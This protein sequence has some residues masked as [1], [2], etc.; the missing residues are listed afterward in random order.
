MKHLLRAIKRLR[1]RYSIVRSFESV[2][3]KN[4]VAA[5]EGTAF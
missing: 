5:D 4:E 3:G 2:P 1:P